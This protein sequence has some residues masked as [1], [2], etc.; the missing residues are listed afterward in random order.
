MHSFFLERAWSSITEWLVTSITVVPLSHSWAP[1]VWCIGFVVFKFT[2]MYDYQR[3][4]S[5][6]SPDST[7]WCHES[8]HVSLGLVSL[9]LVTNMCAVFSNR[10]LS[11]SSDG[12]LREIP[13]PCIIWGCGGGNLGPSWPTTL[14]GLSHTWPWDFYLIIY[15]FYNQPCPAFQG[16]SL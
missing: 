4:V 5:P 6:S 1:S 8:F 15:N 2:S 11:F 7:F 14:K 12:Q 9:Y 13:S 16:V 3:L 10:V